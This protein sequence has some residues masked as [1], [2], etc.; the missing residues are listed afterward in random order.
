VEAAVTTVRRAHRRIKGQSHRGIAYDA[1]DA[2]LSAWVHNSLTDSFLVCAQTFG[3]RR[4]SEGEADRFVA[5]QSRIGRLLDADPLPVTA[6][7]LS[8]WIAEHPAVAPSPGMRDAVDFLLDPPLDPAVKIGY[9][10]LASAAIA[11]VPP[12]I[13]QVLGVKPRPGALQVGGV[14]MLGMRWALG[15]SPRW[16]QALIRVG[17]P[18]DEALFKQK[19]PFETVNAA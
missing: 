16:R 12:R 2:E 1:D 6:A 7:H 9:Q 18:V 5:E 3:A 14:A 11:T 15:A 8:R 13:R 4:L 19:V 17:A 10:V